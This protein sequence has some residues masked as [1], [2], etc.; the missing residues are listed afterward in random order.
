MLEFKTIQSK[1]III[2]S[3]LEIHYLVFKYFQNKIT[4]LS[5]FA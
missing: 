4:F 1:N 3:V 2:K 5:I